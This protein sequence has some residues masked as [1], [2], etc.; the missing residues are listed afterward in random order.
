MDK[1]ETEFNTALGHFEY[2]VMFFG[3]T[4]APAVFQALVNDFLRVSLYHFIFVYL[5]DILI[6]TCTSTE[7]IHQVLQ[8]LLENCL[9]VK[10][11]KCQFHAR[12]VTFLW[13]IIESEQVKA[14]PE[15][16]WVIAEWPR[17][18]TL[19]HLQ[20]FL[21][22]VNFYHCFSRDYSQIT[23]PFI[24][25]TSTSIYFVCL[26]VEVDASDSEVSVVLSQCT[27]PDQKLHLCAA[28]TTCWLSPIEHN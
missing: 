8:Q 7:H 18:T 11:K 6:F 2:L 27:A 13:Y 10:V 5:D 17:P 14:V 26:I 1:W 23:A 9:F 21:W 12:S 28:C 24:M 19:K 3:L 15:K 25:L 16:I 4:N 20:W 22:F